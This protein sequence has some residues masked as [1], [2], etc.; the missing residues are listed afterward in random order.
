MAP[1]VREFHANLHDM[2]GSTVYVQVVSVPFDRSTIN[3]FFGL[4]DEDSEEYRALYRKPN[5]DRILKELTDGKLPWKRGASNE[6][7]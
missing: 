7:Q 3:R 2:I 4:Q 6:V 1:I 5:Y